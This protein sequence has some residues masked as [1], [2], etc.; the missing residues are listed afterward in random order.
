MTGR[1]YCWLVNLRAESPETIRRRLTRRG[2]PA[3]D[4]DPGRLIVPSEQEARR[5]WRKRMLGI[6]RFRRGGMFLAALRRLQA[7]PRPAVL[8]PRHAS[9]Q[10]APTAALAPSGLPV[11]DLTPALPVL[12]ARV[13]L[14][15]AP[16]SSRALVPAGVP[17]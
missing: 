8:A 16:P 6:A 1:G 5:I 7:R 12:L 2:L 13:T 15:A 4:G 10:V 9:L 17:A 3:F 14:T 11:D